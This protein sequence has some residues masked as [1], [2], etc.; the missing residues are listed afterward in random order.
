MIWAR[1]IAG[2]RDE[3]SELSVL[4]WKKVLDMRAVSRYSMYSGAE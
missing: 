1:G 4:P 2:P 3:A